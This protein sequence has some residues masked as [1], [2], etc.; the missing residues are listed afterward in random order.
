MASTADSTAIITEWKKDLEDL[1]IPDFDQ[2]DVKQEELGNGLFG[3][4]NV[5]SFNGVSFSAKKIHITL[6]SKDEF[7]KNFANDCLLFSKLRHPHLVQFLGVQISDSFT[8]PVLITELYPLSLATCLQRYPAIPNHSKY[9]ILLE[10]AVGVSYL[11][12]DV[13][14]P[15]VHGHL[16][17]NNILLTEGLHVKISDCI[18]F[19]IGTS[20]PSNSPYQPPEE[21]QVEAGDI[22]CLGDVMLYVAL[23]KEV[24][25]LEFKHHR[26]PDNKNEPVILT[27]IERRERFLK[28]MEETHQLKSSI[29]KCLEED[30][31][32]RPT[33]KEIIEN[34]SKIL[35]DLQPEYQNIL[36]MFM[37]LGQLSLM[38]DSVSS[39]QETVDAKEEEIEALKEQME[40]LNTQLSAKEDII[41]TLK[42]EIEGHKQ[43][44]K[45]KEARVKAHETGVRAKDALIKAK[46]REISAKKQVIATKE[47]LLKSSHKRIE[48]LEQH[49][50][51]S[52]KKNANP[53]P[54]PLISESSKYVVSR[55]LQASPEGVSSNSLGESGL[56]SVKPYRGTSMSPI[57]N[58]GF[59]VQR[60]NTFTKQSAADPKLAEIL[61]RQ[62]KRINNT[63]D[64]AQVDPSPPMR[65]RSN[66][67]DSSTPE[68]RKILQKRKSF[69]EDDS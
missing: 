60:S 10:T 69:V 27:E 23:Q 8:P 25:P 48:V 3:E 36:E 62:Q 11:H 7:R 67:V 49:I 41:R 28:E 57:R 37:A 63:S 12:N 20:T 9:S 54:L 26:N 52:R 59:R 64:D 42:E 17:P 24:N 4:T 50:K 35:K 39:L 32:Q 16:C 14:P 45:N 19:G 22:F 44:L 65:K 53:P 38:K 5:V 13:T 34:L 21:A 47:S 29:L 2:N 33:A 43:A 56:Q 40:P 46:D 55:S 51:T 61:A 15:V 68:L 6:F 31:V 18:R 66:T 58:D 30:P 1:V